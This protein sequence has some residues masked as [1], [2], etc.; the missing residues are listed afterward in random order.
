MPAMRLAQQ[1]AGALAWTRGSI[2]VFYLISVMALLSIVSVLTIRPDAIDHDRAC[3]L[4]DS[5]AKLRA[6]PSR[7]GV[8]LRN[9]ALLIFCLCCVVFHLANA[10]LLPLVGQKLA[11]QDKNS[12]TA[13]MSGCILL[14]QVVMMPMAFLVGRKADLWGRKP[15]FLAGSPYL[16]C[17]VISTRCPTIDLGCSRSK[18]SMASARAYTVH[19]FHS[20]S[21]I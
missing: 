10:A 19:F 2:V 6:E 14:A 11:L 16:P 15:L 1:L 5:S 18:V 8:L 17:A 4:R 12:G 3:G 9:R 20:S 21:R 13:L 7:L